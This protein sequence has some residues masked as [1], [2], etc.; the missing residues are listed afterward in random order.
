MNV[1]SVLTVRG[2]F[3]FNYFIEVLFLLANSRWTIVSVVFLFL[4][5]DRR[6]QIRQQNIH[7]DTIKT[8]K[9]ADK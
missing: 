9:Q 6:Q 7:R 8:K 2:Q 5:T 4:Y 1:D 3:L